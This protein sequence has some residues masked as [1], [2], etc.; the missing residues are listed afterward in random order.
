[1]LVD[2][3]PERHHSWVVQVLELD[4]A[5]ESGANQL[6]DAI[7]SDFG[8]VDYAVSAIGSW[9]QKG[10]CSVKKRLNCAHCATEG[11]YMAC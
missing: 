9:W 2:L 5:T 1:M 8:T 6:A 10:T 7:S 3:V 11:V 4:V